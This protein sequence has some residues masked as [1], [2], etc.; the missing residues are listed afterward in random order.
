MP[1]DKEKKTPVNLHAKHREKLRQR[2]RAEGPDNFEDHQ[3]LELL[4]FYAIPRIDTNEQAHRLLERFGSFRDVFDAKYEDLVSVPGIG[5]STALFI[6]L[7]A[8]TARRY[9]LSES[10]IGNRFET[11]DQVGKYLI[12]LFMGES[13]EKAYILTFN[14]KN[15][16]TCCKL[17]CEGSVNSNAVSPRSIVETAIIEHAVGIVLAHNHPNGLAVPSGSDITSLGTPLL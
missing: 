4:L 9:A 7:I 11:V 10:K 14:G 16:L 6:K 3:A 17:L 5:E 15:E 12:N 1:K 8:A 13:N 2:L